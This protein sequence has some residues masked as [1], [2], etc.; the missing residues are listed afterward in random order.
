MAK[1]WKK[2]PRIVAMRTNRD[3]E[4]R[5]LYNHLMKT[6]RTP[7]VEDFFERNYHVT[8]QGVRQAMER[9]DREP[10]DLGRASIVYIVAI[11]PEFKL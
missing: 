3:R 7:V 6:Y 2:S 1:K 5:D 11:K 9:V 10:V 4:I 8:V